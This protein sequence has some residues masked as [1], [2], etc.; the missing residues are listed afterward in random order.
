MPRLVR[1]RDA[2]LTD[3]DAIAALHT[4][5]RTAYYTAGGVDPDVLVDPAAAERRTQAWAELIEL[6][7]AAV[8]CAVDGEQ[9]VGL[10]AMGP[11]HDEDVQATTH[12]EL[13]QIHVDPD[14]WG[15]G[16]GGAL[17]DAFVERL[18]AAGFTGAVLEVWE[19]NTRA[20]AFYARRDWRDDGVRRPGPAGIDY[21][22]LRLE[23]GAPH[24]DA[25]AP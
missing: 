8:L 16:V 15:D 10:L 18:R 5:A 21:R 12:R 11:P 4:R 3:L 23:L 19:A 17:H 20:R 14:A 1:I 25:T 13:F 24:W 7:D 22:R 2:G 6:S 9:V